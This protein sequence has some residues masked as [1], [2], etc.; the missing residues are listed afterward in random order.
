MTDANIRRVSSV[1]KKNNR[2][3]WPQQLHQRNRNNLAIRSGYC[4]CIIKISNSIFNCYAQR[5]QWAHRYSSS[6][7]REHEKWS[8]VLLQ[9]TLARRR[10]KSESNSTLSQSNCMPKN[11]VRVHSWVHNMIFSLWT[12][13]A[14]C[15]RVYECD[16]PQCLLLSHRRRRRFRRCRWLPSYI[17]SFT[18]AQD[19]ICCLCAL[20]V[21]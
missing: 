20:I 10:N 16:V 15:A 7:A 5:R 11:E 9:I 17:C 6:S 1:W 2:S 3:I 18:T 19:V 8:Q 4:D 13:S 12:S 14:L 21:S